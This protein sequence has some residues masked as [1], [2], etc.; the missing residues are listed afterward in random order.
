M[1][2]GRIEI[3]ARIAKG[4]GIAFGVAGERRGNGRDRNLKWRAVGVDIEVGKVAN[5]RSRRSIDSGI[6]AVA[7]VHRSRWD[8]AEGRADCTERVDTV[9]VEMERREGFPV[10]FGDTALPRG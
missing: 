8:I 10:E 4:K 3:V 6:A 5:K 9:A 2:G 7:A 1:A